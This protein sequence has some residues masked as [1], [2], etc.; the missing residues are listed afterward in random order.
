LKFFN[1]Q[2][3]KQ[4]RAAIKKIIDESPEEITIMRKP[5]VDDGFNGM[6]IDPE[7]EDV[8]YNLKVR[9]SHERKTADYNSA[10]GGL[11]T[12]LSRYITCDYET[13]MYEGDEFN[14]EATQKRYKI[15]LVDPLK[16]LR[17]WL[18]IKHLLLKLQI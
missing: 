12:N 10:P 17:V 18:V 4:A 1:A 15:G 16:N 7:G 8:P 13:I 11:S 3:L 9:L 6:V 5:M 2:L 14:S